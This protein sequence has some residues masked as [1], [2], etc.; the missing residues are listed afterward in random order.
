[1]R[2]GGGLRC[3]G[4]VADPLTGADLFGLSASDFAG[5]WLNGPDL[6]A[7][8]ELIHE[9]LD[10]I[11]ANRRVTTVTQGIDA[12]NVVRHTVTNSSGALTAGQ[13]GVARE[14][15]GDDVRMPQMDLPRRPRSAGPPDR[16][17]FNDHHGEPVGIRYTTGQRN[18]VQASYGTAAHGGRACGSC[19]SAQAANGVAN[20]TGVQ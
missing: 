3:Y 2:L 1:L 19:A 9:P 20:V 13:Q 4:Y 7:A 10:A 11:A 5:R 17:E 15:F 18:R 14:L 16:T 12:E 6:Q 8:V